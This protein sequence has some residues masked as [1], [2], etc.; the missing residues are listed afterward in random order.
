MQGNA[1][2]RIGDVG[3]V[4]DEFELEEDRV[5]VGGQRSA[6]L[7]VRKA[8]TEDALDVAAEVNRI[9]EQ[10]VAENPNVKLTVINDMST[11]VEDRI[12]LLLRNGWQGCIL[13]FATMWLFFNARLS[14]WVVASLPISFLA[15]FALVPSLGLTINM[16]TM[17]GLLMAIGLLMD[18]GI[19]IAENI[20]R[21]RHEGEAAMVA[22]VNG[23]K[24]VGV[25][26]LC[27]RS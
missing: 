20:A 14:F 17:V 1:E 24:E 27:P 25:E 15:A 12:S 9:I 13:V 26:A 23:V 4:V 11:L 5:S 10:Q 19:V 3:R 22:A 7:K 21:R 8:K 2:I 6:V 16:L 18:D